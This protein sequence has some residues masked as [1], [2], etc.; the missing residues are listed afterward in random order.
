MAVLCIALAGS[1]P[2]WAASGVA[3]GAAPARASVD[4]AVRIPEVLS[5]KTLHSRASIYAADRGAVE[6][7]DAASF[8]IRSNLPG[9]GLRFEIRDPDVASVEV[10]GLGEAVVV[11]PAGRVVRFVT[12]RGERT[13]QRTLAY[14]VTYRQGTR[15][16]P[17]PMPVAYSLIGE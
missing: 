14:R 7:A 13:L 2:L 6:V 8:E 1:A 10:E 17:R 4:F 16:G 15:P 11:P 5:L 3:A 12:G 9:Y